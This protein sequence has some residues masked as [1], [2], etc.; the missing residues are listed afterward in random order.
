MAGGLS[1]RPKI[2]ASFHHT[3]ENSAVAF[4]VGR[5]CVC[6][7]LPPPPGRV[8]KHAGH[9]EFSRGI[10]VRRGREKTRAAV[11]EVKV[12][13]SER[14]GERSRGGGRRPTETGGKRKADPYFTRPGLY[15]HQTQVKYLFSS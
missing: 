5:V 14:E 12:G 10:F 4:P 15:T 1:G 3:R 8:Y 11:R 13:E 9:S 2:K 6:V 7:R